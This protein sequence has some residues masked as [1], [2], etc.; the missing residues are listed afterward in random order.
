MLTRTVDRILIDH[1]KISKTA[2]LIEGARQIGKTFSIRQFGK[3][4][5]TYIEINFIEQPEAISL[6]KDLSNTKDLLARLSLFTKQKLIKRD[7]LIFF[8][9]VQI[10]PEVIT[11]IKFLVDEGSY[12]YILSGSLLGIEINDLRSVPVGYLT[13]KRMFPLTFREF[14]LNLG[15]NSSILENLETSFKEK[16][17]VDD[18][19][20]KKMMELFRVYLVVGGMPAAVNRYI[21]TNN[22]N[23]GIDIQNQIVNLYKKD[24]TQYDK[25]NKLA[26]A[27]IFELIAPQLNSQNKRF[28]IKD[29]KSGVKF[30]RYE[31]SFL[32]LKDAGFALPVYNVETPKIPLKLSKS[33]SLFKL[34][35]SDVGLLASEYSQGIQL[36]IISGDDKLN[37]GAIFENYI[38]QEL[39]ACEHDLYYYN[40]KKRGELDFLIEYDGEVLPIEVKSGKDY[41]VHRALSNIMDCGEFNLNRAL[42][43]NNSNLKVEGKLTYAPIYMAMFLKQEIND[44]DSIYKIDLS[45]LNKR[46]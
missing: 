29:I 20:H 24:I 23:E 41:K 15:L 1:F 10:C 38:A 26:I 11:Y 9:E 35:M 34:F 16:K 33:R 7:T 42:I 21:E 30:D 39:T 37:Y 31:N 12:N 46:F 19:I 3:K 13:I 5:K 6:F 45:E 18:F 44:E 8:D 17:P 4:F 28:I 25:N 43:F 40:N 2:L 22:L 14:A 27:Q 32:W 36:K